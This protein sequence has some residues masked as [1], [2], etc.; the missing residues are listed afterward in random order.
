MHSKSL[1]FVFKKEWH[2]WFAGDLTESN[3]KKSDS[4]EKICIF[5]MFFT[6]PPFYAQ[7]QIA[8]VALRTL[9]FTKEWPWAQCSRRSL[10][11]NDHQ[12]CVIFRDRIAHSLNNRRVNSQPWNIDDWTADLESCKFDLSFWNLTAYPK[13]KSPSY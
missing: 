6:F 9:L 3:S 11:K 5:C 12:R 2:Q 1:S 10:K 7:E 13:V 4:L 8:P